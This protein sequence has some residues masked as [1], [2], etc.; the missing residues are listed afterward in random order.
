MGKGRLEAFSDG[1]IAIIITIMVLE[2]KVPA[3]ATLPALLALLPH[4]LIYA[5]SFVYVGIYWNNH[6]HMF[7]AA[8]TVSG[9]ILWANLHLLFWLSLLPFASAWMGEHYR[10]SLPVAVYGGLLFMCGMAYMILTRMLVKHEGPD[11]VLARAVGPDTKTLGSV[12]GYIIGILLSP[13]V[14]LVSSAIYALVAVAWFIPDRRIEK[15]LA[16][17]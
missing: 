6:H 17:E 15:A 7:H 14:P 9:G 1:V 5:L 12:T 4:V 10:E 13:F 2:F 3:E 16:R 11:S 8:R